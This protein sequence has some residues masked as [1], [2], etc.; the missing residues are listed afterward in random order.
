MPQVNMVK[1]KL[2]QEIDRLENCCMELEK[3]LDP[4]VSPATPT[5]AG[6]NTDTTT[7]CMLATNIDNMYARVLRQNNV[8]AS[9]L[10]RLEI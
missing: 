10:G 4:V 3:R 2:C 5:P 6:M 7:T 8:L 9:I 1:E